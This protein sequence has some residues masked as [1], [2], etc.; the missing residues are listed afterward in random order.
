[1]MW[2]AAVVLV[3]VGTFA[4]DERVQTRCALHIAPP[5]RA[6]VGAVVMHLSVSLALVSPGLVWPIQGSQR[7]FS[8]SW[9]P[10]Q[11]LTNP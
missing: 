3:V 11:I 5:F 6:L 8:P 1:M 4:L 9:T 2:P 10:S 7:E